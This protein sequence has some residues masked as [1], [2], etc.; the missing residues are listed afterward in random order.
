MNSTLEGSNV[1][2]S[3]Q[4]VRKNLYQKVRPCVIETMASC[5]LT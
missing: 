5:V 3:D 2:V 4:G 1:I